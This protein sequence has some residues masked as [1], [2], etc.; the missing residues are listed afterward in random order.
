MA[1][2]QVCAG[3]AEALHFSGS[4]E[5]PTFSV[6]GTLM[7]GKTVPVHCPISR[8]SALQR[9]AEDPRPWELTQLGREELDKYFLITGSGVFG[10]A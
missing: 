3:W 6:I 8:L 7:T 5:D 9:R 10:S 1:P 4:G 2:L